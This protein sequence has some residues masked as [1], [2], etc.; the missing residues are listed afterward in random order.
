M[1]APSPQAIPAVAGWTAVHAD[2]LAALVDRR[3]G[4]AEA[5][6]G[7]GTDISPISDWIR[8]LFPRSRV[9]YHRA[10]SR[11]IPDLFTASAQHACA[12]CDGLFHNGVLRRELFEERSGE[13]AQQLQS[14]SGPGQSDQP[15]ARRP[16]FRFDREYARSR[17]DS[18]DFA[19]AEYSHQSWILPTGPSRFVSTSLF[20]SNLNL[21]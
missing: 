10:L 3:T 15:S 14:A 2:A 1:I 6:F 20:P 5:A 4:P 19:F 11:D 12:I 7:H 13:S 9:A 18:L 8:C 16:A 17:S 21:L